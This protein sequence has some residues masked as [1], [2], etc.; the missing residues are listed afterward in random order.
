MLILASKS[1]HKLDFKWSRVNVMDEQNKE[2]LLR[3]GPERALKAFVNLPDQPGSTRPAEEFCRLY[4]KLISPR[5]SCDEIPLGRYYFYVAVLRKAWVAR[6]KAEKIKASQQLE[7]I[8][9]RHA[10]VSAVVDRPAFE[11]DLTSKT[12]LRLKGDNDTH[13]L[14]LMVWTMLH[15]RERLATCKRT[16]CRNPYFIKPSTAPR[17]SYCSSECSGRL[18]KRGK[19]SWWRKNRGKGSEW[20]E[21]ARKRAKNSTSK[22]K[23]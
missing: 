6:T 11:V 18:R 13:L 4:G 2:A 12:S 15:A 10:W 7:G 20:W 19:R 1:R 5:V 16:A 3:Y 9:N 14:D 17:Q 22:S 21:A 8:L 23:R